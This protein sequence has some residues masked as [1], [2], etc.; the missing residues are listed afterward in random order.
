MLEVSEFVEAFNLTASLRLVAL[1]KAT[2]S[3]SVTVI[4]L[5]PTTILPMSSDTTTLVPRSVVVLTVDVLSVAVPEK[6]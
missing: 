5:P 6:I 2:G 3:G 1:D 4:N